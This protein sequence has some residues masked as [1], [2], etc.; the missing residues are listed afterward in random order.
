MQIGV[1]LEHPWILAL[2]P[3]FVVFVILAGKRIKH[4]PTHK[5]RAAQVLR[6][7]LMLALTLA[8]A[9]PSVQSKAGANATIFAADI[10]DSNK[11]N[12]D[13]I[14]NFIGEAM[15]HAGNKDLTGVIS[16]AAESSVLKMPSKESTAVSVDTRI[17]SDSTNIEKAIVLARS[18]MPENTAK[19]IVL[20]TDGKETAGNAIEAAG[21]VNRLGFTVD[22]VPFEQD[23][24]AEVQIDEF[25]APKQVNAGERFDISV[26]ISGTTDTKAT[27]RLFANRTLTAEK[28]VDIY[29]GTNLFTFSDKVEQGGIVTYTVEVVTPDDTILQNN[30]LSAFT[31]ILDQP[32][33]LVIERGNA[34]E[35]I[36]RYIEQY[37][38]ITRIQPE[39]APDDIQ[40][41]MAYDA[42]VMVDISAEW[43]SVGFLNALEQ[44]VKYQGKGLLTIGGENSYAPGGYNNTPL[45]TIL[46]VNMDITPKDENPDL[47]LILVIDK[48]GSMSG[49]EYGISKLQLAKEAA[50]RAAE[51]LEETDQLGVIAFDD[52]IQWVVR[53]RPLED[54][55]ETINTIATIR[56][57][58]GTQIL[59]P[60]EEAWQ[61][62][63]KKDTKLKHIILLTDGQAEQYGYE[64][65]I[66]GI[67]EDG[68]TLSTVAVGRGADTLLLKALA[69]GGMGRYYQ[70]DEFSDIPSIFAK[71]AFLAGQKYIQ[72]RSFYP[73]LVSSAGLLKGI[74]AIPMLD[75]YV[76][77]KVKATAQTVF[78]SDIQDPILAV[79][80]YGLGRTA[81][82]TSDIRGAWTSKWNMWQD[83]PAF[84]GNL[85]GWLIQKDINAGYSVK[86]ELRDGRGYIVI[87]SE[88]EKTVYEEMLEGTVVSPDGA[89]ETI[90]FD[91]IKPGVYEAALNKSDPGAYIVHVQIP[92]EEGFENVSAGIVM[93]YSN[94]YRFINENTRSFI[95][96]L[97]K[98]GGGRVITNPEEVFKGPVQD[99]RA[100]NDIT[101][102]LIIVA[103]CLLMADIAFRK[104][105]ISLDP[106][107][108]FVNEKV[109]P[110]F[111]RFVKN[112]RKKPAVLSSGIPADKPAA[113]RIDMQQ[114]SK[115]EKPAALDMNKKPAASDTNKKSAA[116]DLNKEPVAQTDR[117]DHINALLNRRKKWK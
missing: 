12:M 18:I 11:K 76:C 28:E 15:K 89:E 97:A 109:Y 98:A 23:Y 27:V 44:A 31:E 41:L 56:P 49:G 107:L 64:R 22:V 113:V 53:T 102:L 103:L 29:K 40:F 111:S 87:E 8:A 86:T 25:T 108:L 67:R 46:P 117:G 63:R 82:W 94:E 2:F 50:I 19:R 51:V 34:G 35:N 70:T 52:A 90:R 57:G 43:V 72:N 32:S 84:W 74:E 73:E 61:D 104:L 9:S 101:N 14:E 7:I 26:K 88:L 38:N 92:S 37:A 59:P 20:L 105:K 47:G 85:I 91:A 78:R 80:Q 79:W 100:K 114:D 6:I 99:L 4:M 13:R 116:P 112:I 45:E 30:R 106:A 81:A 48:S 96:K 60:L 5:K 24:G 33:V 83:A 68:I 65:I 54:R 66:E 93:P 115:S 16:F 10:S 1:T 95:E 39:E 62:L 21:L 75:G 3:V 77:T 110:A 55:E 58:G 69:Y 36:V 42:Y 71:E 17:K